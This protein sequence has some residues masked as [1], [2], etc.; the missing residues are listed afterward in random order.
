MTAAHFLVL[1]APGTGRD[2]DASYF[3]WPTDR[4]SYGWLTRLLPPGKMQIPKG[5]SQI[6]R[7]D[8]IGHA[9]GWVIAGIRPRPAGW[10]VC[11]AASGR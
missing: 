4:T 8:L 1:H 7:D 6:G 9:E 3:V 10:E 11:G 2:D 5:M